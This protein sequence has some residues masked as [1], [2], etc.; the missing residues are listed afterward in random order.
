MNGSKL[1]KMSSLKML[2]LFLYSKQDWGSYIISIAKT[3]FQ[4]IGALIRVLSS[5]VSPS[6]VP[7]S[8]TWNNLVIFALV[9]P[10][11]TWLCWIKNIIR[12]LLVLH[13]LPI[14]SPWL[15][16]KIWPVSDFFMGITLVHVRQKSLYWIIYPILM[17]GLVVILII[18]MIWMLCQQFLPSHSFFPMTYDL[19]SR[20]NRYVPLIFGLFLT[21][22]PLYVFS[23]SST[24]P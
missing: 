3:V 12:R 18:Y 23:L 21:E 24:F 2:V 4:K 15:I 20:S 10:T 5:D 16:V 19:K 8:L 6:D 9:F 7:P 14:W 22:F 17:E 1:H 11:T 13:L